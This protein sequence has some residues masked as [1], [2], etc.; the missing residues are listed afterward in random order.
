MLVCSNCN[1]H[2][3][4]GKFCGVCGGALKQALS[5]EQFNGSIEQSG[6]SS[7]NS[8]AAALETQAQPTATAIKS[9]VSQYW[10]YF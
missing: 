8:G 7:A 4:D 10:S 2:Q 1:N 9:G 6:V 5:E 3:E